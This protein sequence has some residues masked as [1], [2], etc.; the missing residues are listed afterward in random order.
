MYQGVPRYVS[1]FSRPQSLSRQLLERQID[2]PL[3]WMTFLSWSMHRGRNG[4]RG[5]STWWHT[6]S[7]SRNTTVSTMVNAAAAAAPPEVTA[8]L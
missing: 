1:T 4:P 6:P 7:M 2:A 3:P 5:S 8:K